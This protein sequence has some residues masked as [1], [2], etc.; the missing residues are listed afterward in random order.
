[1]KQARHL[2]CRAPAGR[3][4][5]TDLNA[6]AKGTP[7]AVRLSLISAAGPASSE[8]RDLARSGSG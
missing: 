8:Q 4:A 7:P 5:A 1:L 2:Q 6:P 3:N